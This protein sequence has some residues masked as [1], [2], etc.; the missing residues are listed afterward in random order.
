MAKVVLTPQAATGLDELPVTIHVRIL[1]ILERLAKWPEV[2]GARP[3]S[4][5]LSGN[6]RMRTG[7]YRVQFYTQGQ[8]GPDATVVVEKIG[9]RDG[10]YGE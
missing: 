9:H 6:Y 8:S 4:G 5:S 7:D 10:F 2:S 3:L 1:R